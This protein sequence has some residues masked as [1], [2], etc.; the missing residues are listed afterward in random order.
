MIIDEK[1]P[2]RD[3]VS[4]Y[5]TGFEI[6]ETQSMKDGNNKQYTQYLIRIEHYSLSWEL[7]KRF[8]DFDHLRQQL[9]NQPRDDS[10]AIPP[11]FVPSLP[12][13]LILVGGSMTQSV[14]EE[15]KIKLV[16]FMNTLLE[17][18]DKIKPNRHSKTVDHHT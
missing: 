3:S 2:N 14:V 7:E 8:S 4:A 17:Y 12:S 11:E 18:H 16:E 5:R 1:Q 6:F 15:R 9:L 10:D 13:K